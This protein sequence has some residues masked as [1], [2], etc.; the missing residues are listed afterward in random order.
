MTHSPSSTAGH[1]PVAAGRVLIG[2][3]IS[4]NVAGGEPTVAITVT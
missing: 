3:E 1:E 2:A 4:T